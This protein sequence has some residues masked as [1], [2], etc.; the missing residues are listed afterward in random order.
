MG[1]PPSAAAVEDELVNDLAKHLAAAYLAC[2][3][4]IAFNAA[5]RRYVE[6]QGQVSAVWKV[7]ARFILDC[8]AANSPTPGASSTGAGEASAPSAEQLRQNGKRKAS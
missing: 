5:M 6:P 8:Q 1:T 4:G 7:G 3:M 2:Q